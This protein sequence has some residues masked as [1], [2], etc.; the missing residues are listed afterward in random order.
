M[1]LNF[2]CRCGKSRLPM[3]GITRCPFCGATYQTLE[4][5]KTPHV[6]GISLWEKNRWVSFVYPSIQKDIDEENKRRFGIHD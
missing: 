1:L 6:L 3:V 2:K 4:E 5:V